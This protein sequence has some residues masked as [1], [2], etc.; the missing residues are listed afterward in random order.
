[1]RTLRVASNASAFILEKF[2]EAASKPCLLQVSHGGLIDT[3]SHIASMSDLDA[4][5]FT[6]LS[7]D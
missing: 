5:D 7:V 4:L 3:M 2:S 6:K 1:M